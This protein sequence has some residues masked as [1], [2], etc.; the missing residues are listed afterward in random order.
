MLPQPINQCTHHK[1]GDG[2]AENT[3]QHHYCVL[4]TQR[5]EPVFHKIGIH[6]SL[7][8]QQVYA[9]GQGRKKIDDS[10]YQFWEITLRESDQQEYCAQEHSR[11]R[12]A[13]QRQVFDEA[14]IY[15]IYLVQPRER[16]GNRANS[17]CFERRKVN[18]I[19]GKIPTDNVQIHQP[20]GSVAVF[21]IK[22]I[23]LGAQGNEGK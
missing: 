8:V 14:R 12:I 22:Q 20:Q 7:G 2:D 6:R 5:A 18:G 1:P 13:Q 15:I 11:G 17:E 16:N 4:F 10:S 9:K 19:F 3:Q 21:K 23:G